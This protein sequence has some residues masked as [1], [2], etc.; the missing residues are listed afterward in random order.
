MGDSESGVGGKGGENEKQSE[1]RGEGEIMES[2]SEKVERER[3][4]KEMTEENDGYWRERLKRDIYREKREILR[5]K[6]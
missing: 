3:E 2:W 5:N 1:K 6:R 4:E